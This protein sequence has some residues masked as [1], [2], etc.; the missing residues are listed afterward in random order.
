MSTVGVLRSSLVGARRR[1]FAAEHRRWPPARTLKFGDARIY[2]SP[3]V[4]F[5][6]S[7]ASS[8]P[9]GASASDAVAGEPAPDLD[10][11]CAEALIEKAVYCCRFFA[12][13]G[14]TGALVGSVLCFF[15]GCVFIVTAFLEY[16]TS[17]PKAMSAIIEAID[18]YLIGTV[19]LVFGMGIYELFISNL[20]MANISSKR[21]NL[22]GLF[23]LQ[24]RPKW[25]EIKSVNSL[26]TKLGHVIVMA[27][28]VGLFDKIQKVAIAT[29]A[30][31][32][33]LSASILISSC[34]LL[35]LSKLSHSGDK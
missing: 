32:L 15:K 19:M 2:S 16:P 26:K 9:P 8:S 18:I 5:C 34:G 12:L 4:A 30:D 28:L 11:Y 20:D 10:I 13:L 33:C 31:L 21:S 17:R 6:S 35:L 1:I 27:L 3:A 7:P 14:V 24:E 29:P 25:L 22:L 23:T